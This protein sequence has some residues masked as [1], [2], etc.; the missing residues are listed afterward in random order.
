MFYFHIILALAIL[1]ITLNATYISPAEGKPVPGDPKA[2]EEVMSG[3]KKE[4]K[5]CLKM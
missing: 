5:A 4:A 3:K 1:A 2:V